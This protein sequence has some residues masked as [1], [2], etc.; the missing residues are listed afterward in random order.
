MAGK[1]RYLG[2]RGPHGADVILLAALRALA[3]GG[4]AD[5][6]MH[7]LEKPTTP[8]KAETRGREEDRNLLSP[9]RGGT[10]GRV[11]RETNWVGRQN[12]N[13]L[14]DGRSRTGQLKSGLLRVLRFAPVRRQ[15]AT[16]TL[17]EVAWLIAI[18]TTLGHSRTIEAPSCHPSQPSPQ[19]VTNKLQE[20][21]SGKV[22]CF[23]RDAAAAS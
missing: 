12:L 17:F 6:G 10:N 16:H 3:K 2:K 23:G 19:F 15:P 18:Q 5:E 20:Q 21:A 4:M 7:R 13:G 14:R 8:Q 11:W 9:R 22:G 1:S